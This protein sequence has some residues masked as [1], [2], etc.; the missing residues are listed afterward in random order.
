MENSV[1]QPNAI[2][3]SIITME[4]VRVYTSLNFQPRTQR[5]DVGVK[6]D[7]TVFCVNKNTVICEKHFR[8]QEIIR[9]LGGVRCRL[10]KDK[11]S[12]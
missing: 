8:K 9:G 7:K 11:V 12:Q 6:M 1:L 10:S 2:V 3:L 4:V 5:K